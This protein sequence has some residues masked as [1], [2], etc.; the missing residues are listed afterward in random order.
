MDEEFAGATKRREPM[1]HTTTF[2]NQQDYNNDRK[3]Y[4]AEFKTRSYHKNKYNCYTR[5]L[6][7]C[8]K[9]CKAKINYIEKGWNEIE[10][11]K[12]KSKHNHG[13]LEFKRETRNKYTWRKTK[14]FRT[15]EE[16]KLEMKNVKKQFT[17]ANNGLKSKNN[18]ITTYN[19][20]KLASKNCKGKVKPANKPVYQYIIKIQAPF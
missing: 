8:R 18:T 7:C 6:V 5:Y 9:E 10:K 1:E 11:F 13:K 20:L 4:E 2:T 14:E 15:M 19:C 3:I 16:Y 17:R 12:S